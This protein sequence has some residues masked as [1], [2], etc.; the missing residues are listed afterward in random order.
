MLNRLHAIWP[1]DYQGVNHK[2]EP[3]KRRLLEKE[4]SRKRNSGRY[5]TPQ[6][7][8]TQFKHVIHLPQTT[9]NGAKHS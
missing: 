8:N 4:G 1:K 6:L 9:N 5:L 2:E 7:Y 3:P